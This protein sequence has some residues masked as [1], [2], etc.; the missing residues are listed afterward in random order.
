MLK[1]V[2]TL[3]D[4]SIAVIIGIAAL[5]EICLAGTLLPGDS[6]NAPFWPTVAEM[7][8]LAMVFAPLMFLHKRTVAR[9]QA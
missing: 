8:L 2:F 9:V 5:V 1:I 4:W 6:I 7:A 3:I